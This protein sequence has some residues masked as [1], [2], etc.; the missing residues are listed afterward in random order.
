MRITCTGVP[1]LSQLQDKAK[2]I[3][4]AR[5]ASIQIETFLELKNFVTQHTSV[6]Q[7]MPPSDTQLAAQQQAQLATASGS[8]AL[9]LVYMPMDNAAYDT[10]GVCLTGQMQ[11]EWIQMLVKMLKPPAH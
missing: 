2:N 11:I 1:T 4:K 6:P 9:P 7:L 3:K 8:K 5:V 10:Q